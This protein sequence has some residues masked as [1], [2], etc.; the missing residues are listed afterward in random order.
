MG[1]LDKFLSGR[2]DDQFPNGLKS[3]DI[4]DNGGSGCILFV[5]DRRGDRDND[6]EYDS[7]PADLFQVFHVG[8]YGTSISPTNKRS[9]SVCQKGDNS[10]AGAL[11]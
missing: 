5:S 10:R 6:G 9:K 3:T 2:W 4:P 8:I 11:D 1:N 7:N